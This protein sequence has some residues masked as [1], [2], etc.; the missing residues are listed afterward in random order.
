MA[1]A[2]G[3]AILGHFRRPIA[4][5]NKGPHGEYD[6]V[7]VADRAAE[8]AIC[9]LIAK[10][11][12]EHG[13]VGEEFGVKNPGARYTWVID[14]IDGTRAFVT[15]S[16][17]WGTLIGLLDRDK[18]VLGLMDQPYTGERFWSANRGA[19]MRRAGG[20]ARRIRTRSCSRVSDAVLMSTH[21]DL[22]AKGAEARGFANVKGRVRMSRFGGDCYSYCL[23]A[24]GFVDVVIEAGL[25]SFDV[26]AHIPIIEQAGGCITD[27]QGGSAAAGGQVVA[28][29]DPKL[30]GEV[31]K[32]LAG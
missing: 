20:K 22:F 17:L 19:F 23:L 27:W 24:A 32:L 29:G 12:P 11:W 8:R 21:P 1:D 31:L 15:G 14:P 2:S 4:V 9:R 25:K 3:A 28:T 5:E 16:L 7:T 18:P 13:V 30:H 6:P 10:S 26:V